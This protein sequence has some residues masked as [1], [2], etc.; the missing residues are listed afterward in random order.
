MNIRKLAWKNLFRRKS[1]AVFTELG[2]LLGIGTFV[3]LAS[4]TA[5]IGGTLK[6]R[7]I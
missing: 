6:R 2:I 3:A 7:G 4:L 1:R 5:Q